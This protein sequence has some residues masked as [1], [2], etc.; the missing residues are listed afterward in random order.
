MKF[1]L[2]FPPLFAAI[3]LFPH[4]WSTNAAARA[5]ANPT[6]LDRVLVVVNDD[7]IT[8]SELAARVAAVK[9]QL[10]ARRIKLP[11]ENVLRQQVMDSMILERI[12]LDRAKKLG[13]SVDDAQIDHAIEDLAKRNRMSVSQ[14]YRHARQDHMDRKSLREDIRNQII[15]SQLVQRE[16]RDKVT[17][18]EHEVDAFLRDQKQH[19]GG[20]EEFNLSH[21]LIPVPDSANRETRQRARMLAQEIRAK[22]MQG[23]SFEQYALRYSKGPTA[24]QGGVLGW[25]KAGQLPGVLLK[26][27]RALKPGQVSRVIAGSNGYHLLRLNA[28]RGGK[29]DNKVTQTHV[30]HILIRPSAIRTPAQSEQLAKLLRARILAGESFAN[31]ARADSDDAASGSHG[32]DLGWVTPGQMVPEFEAAMNKLKPGQISQPVRSRYGYHLIEVLGRRQ[33]DIG[34]ERKRVSARQQ[35]AERKNEERLQ[36]WQRQLREEAYVEVLA[37]PDS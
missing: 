24:L 36:E 23:G 5:A 2:L 31:I 22:V 28:R 17:V 33:K 32:G 29:L 6:L 25:R 30:R 10:A 27:V 18:S 37:S 16:V 12:E 14:F 15:I 13:I 8:E 11:P 7:V 19:G 26:A 4:P 34:K 3:L 35:I 9:R 1:R 21:I 20:G